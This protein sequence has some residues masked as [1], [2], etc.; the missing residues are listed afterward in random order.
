MAVFLLR[1]H[2]RLESR[3]RLS[4]RG[5]HSVRWPLTRPTLTYPHGE[6]SINLIYQHLY[7]YTDFSKKTS[8]STVPHNLAS[9]PQPLN[10]QLLYVTFFKCL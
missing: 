5:A 8:F 2:G 4:V 6:H 7:F 1:P 9:P 10:Y 3:G